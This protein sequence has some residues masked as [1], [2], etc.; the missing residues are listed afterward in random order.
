MIT[1]VPKDRWDS[2]GYYGEDAKAGTKANPIRGGFIEDADKF[3]AAFFSISPREAR[4]M[5]PQQRIL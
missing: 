4:L 1:E 2:E 3:D 5:D